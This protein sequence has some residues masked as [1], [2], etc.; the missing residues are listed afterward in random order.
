MRLLR[1]AAGADERTRSGHVLLQYGTPSLPKHM[2]DSDTRS[3]A[4]SES[5]G[6]FSILSPDTMNRPGLLVPTAEKPD[7][8]GWLKRL[9]GLLS[10]AW[11]AML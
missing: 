6:A 8:R 5:F 9:S 7:S 1:R 10:I 3:W 4:R 11:S 2:Q